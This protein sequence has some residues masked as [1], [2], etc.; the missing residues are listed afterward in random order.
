MTPAVIGIVRVGTWMISC[1]LAVLGLVSAGFA[2]VVP[3]LVA[4]FIGGVIGW[5]LARHRGLGASRGWATASF[6]AVTTA[7]VILAAVGLVSLLGPVAIPAAAALGGLLLWL[8]RRR[9]ERAA[10]PQQGSE[11]APLRGLSNVQLARAWRT[12]YNDLVAARDAL[13]LSRVCSLRRRQLDEIERRDPTG[14]HR[15]INSGYWVRGDSAPFLG[16]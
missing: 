7:V 10:A 3:G 1:A 8:H 4:S 6:Y 11:E 16:L 14:F 13:T 5:A 9:A 15:W 2:V 12:S